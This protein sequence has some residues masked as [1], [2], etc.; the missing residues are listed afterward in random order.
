MLV[1]YKGLDSSCVLNIDCKLIFDKKGQTWSTSDA[2]CITCLA[3]LI[4]IVALV[5]ALVVGG[6][7]L[8]CGRDR[9]L[10]WW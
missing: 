3:L 1:V 9:L 5:V 8:C 4:I 6:V 7:V 10:D 2:A